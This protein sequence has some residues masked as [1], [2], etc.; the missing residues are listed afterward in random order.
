MIGGKAEKQPCLVVN[1][2][3]V[4]LSPFFHIH[5]AFVH[6]VQFVFIHLTVVKCD[7]I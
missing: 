1:I 4:R 7:F 5:Y 2:L 3:F 6:V